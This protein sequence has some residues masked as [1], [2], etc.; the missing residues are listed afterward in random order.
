MAE[1]TI[2]Y[3]QQ[4]LG[5]PEPGYV[6]TVERTPEIGHAL[7]AGYAIEMHLADGE[8]HLLQAD[9]NDSGAAVSVDGTPAEPA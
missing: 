1:V 2:V 4:V 3:R 8:P 7:R 9:I 6:L 5:G